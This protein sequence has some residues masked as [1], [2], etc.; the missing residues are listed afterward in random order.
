MKSFF[1]IFFATLLAFVVFNFVLLMILIGIASSGEETPVPNNAYLELDLNRPIVEMTS[2]DPF[3]EIAQAFGNETAPQ[4][5]KNILESLENAANDDNIKGVYLN[6]SNV[7]AGFA[8]I[9]EI[10]NGLIDFKASGKPVIAYAETFSEGGYYVASVADEIILNPVGML[11]FNGLSSEVTFFKGTF[12]K[13]NIEPQIFRVGTFKS[14]VEPFIRKDM[15]DASKQQI[16]ELL[17]SVYGH[18]LSNVAE[19]R[20]IPIEELTNISD[21][22]LVREAEDALKYGLVT[23]LG[24]YD[25][26]LS[27]IRNNIGLEADADVPTVSIKDYKKSFVAEP[28]QQNRIAVIVAEGNI[29]SG[30][31]DGKSIGSE[32]FAKEIRKARLDDK[33][34]AIVIRINSPGGSALASDVMWREVKLAKQVK[35]VIASMSSVAASGGYYMA[36][37]C[38]TIVAQPNTITGSIGIFAII[39]DLSNFMDSKLGITFDRVST[40]EYS[41]LFTVTRSLNDAEKQIIQNMVE[42][43]YEDFTTKAAEGRNMPVEALLEVASG[44]VWSGIEAHERGLVDVLGGYD[45]AIRIAAQSAGLE[46]GNYMKVYYPEQKPLF[47]KL[48]EDLGSSANIFYQKVIYGE[49]SPYVDEFKYVI[50]N[51]G[52]Q[53]RMPFDLEI[54]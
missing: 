37:A 13:L 29:I 20:G 28:Y 42:R 3:A 33:I 17:N 52:L 14:A 32:K 40:G 35:P 38:D 26:V 44:R 27:I 25:E 46:E 48:M 54:K 36:M 10:R 15:S 1:K 11:E 12:E 8:Q 53:T 24:Y 45:D 2:E 6:A 47:Q 21:Q 9:E 31:G 30:E 4:S 22:Y 16:G 23:Q 5:L 34:K 19:A 50:E 43:G 18:Y 51:K 41:D 7:I 49:A 39:P